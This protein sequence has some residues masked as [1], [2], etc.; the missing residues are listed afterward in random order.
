[1]RGRIF[2]KFPFFSPQTQNWS[3]GTKY[4]HIKSYFK[5]AGFGMSTGIKKFPLTEEEWVL[6]LLF[7]LSSQESVQI[8]PSP[9]ENY[10]NADAYSL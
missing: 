6:F 3:A 9:C 1:M 4:E 7:L 8:Y 2:F 10:R 5:F